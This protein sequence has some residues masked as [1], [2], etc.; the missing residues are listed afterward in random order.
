LD[1]EDRPEPDHPRHAVELRNSIDCRTRDGGASPSRDNR[2]NPSADSV[3]PAKD[4]SLGF[5]IQAGRADGR[6]RHA[7][8]EQQN[9]SRYDT[10]GRGDARGLRHKRRP[11]SPHRR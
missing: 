1:I 3:D 6:N 5:D 4:G 8:C 7:C 9:E 10:S 11:G 2:E